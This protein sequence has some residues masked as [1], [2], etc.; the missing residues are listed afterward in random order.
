MV[1]AFAKPL[2]GKLEGR[3]TVAGGQRRQEKRGTHEIK[4]ATRA[5]TGSIW[6]KQLILIQDEQELWRGSKRGRFQ[7]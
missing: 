1:T 3:A 7:F 4:A 6:E 5:R 2:G